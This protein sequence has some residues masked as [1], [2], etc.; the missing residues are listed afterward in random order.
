MPPRARAEAGHLILTVTN[1][2]RDIAPEILPFLFQ[3]FLRGSTSGSEGLGLGLYIA[4]QIARAHHGTLT[5]RSAG[6]STTFEFSM[7]VN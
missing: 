5:V 2:G 3:P 7:P 6:G 4:D 1:T